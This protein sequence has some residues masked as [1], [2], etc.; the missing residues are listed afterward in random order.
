M[1]PIGCGASP[2]YVARRPDGVGSRSPSG[3][4]DDGRPRSR[5][6]TWCDGSAWG[7]PPDV[8]MAGFVGTALSTSA[9]HSAS[10]VGV[11]PCVHRTFLEDSRASVAARH[12]FPPL[13]CHCV[14]DT[15]G[16]LIAPGSV[17]VPNP[18]PG[19]PRSV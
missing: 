9:R 12:P 6:T 3:R 15:V 13:K 18:S 8:R 17:D 7:I 4:D 16:L 2:S 14:P 10:N 11:P 5:R 1:D 19:I